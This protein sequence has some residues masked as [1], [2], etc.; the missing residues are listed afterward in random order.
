M[1]RKSTR[2]K[3]NHP[4]GKTSASKHNNPKKVADVETAIKKKRN[5]RKGNCFNCGCDEV[6]ISLL[7]FTAMVIGVVMLIISRPRPIFG[8]LTSLLQ[9]G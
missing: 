2:S 7:L 1:G 9:R 8:A 3:P 4:A 6:S 5:V